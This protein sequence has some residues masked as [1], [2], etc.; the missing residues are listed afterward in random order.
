MQLDK[1]DVEQLESDIEE[2]TSVINI[3]TAGQTLNT[4]ETARLST[5]IAYQIEQTEKIIEQI[6]KRIEAFELEKQAIDQQLYIWSMYGK[7]H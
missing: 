4:S 6:N 5:A 1:T 2:L 7:I 3:M